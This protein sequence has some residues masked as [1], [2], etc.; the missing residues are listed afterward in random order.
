MEKNAWN[1]RI[2]KSLEKY[3]INSNN[4]FAFNKWL[5]KQ[6]A[7]TTLEKNSIFKLLYNCI[8]DRDVLW[9]KGLKRHP[10]CF[11]CEMEYEN[12]PHLFNA[13]DVA[14]PYLIRADAGTL[15]KKFEKLFT[16]LKTKTVSTILFGTY[17]EDK[18]KALFHL[19]RLYQTFSFT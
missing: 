10:L 19:N 3:S 17:T 9:D 4:L 6:D 15:G 16:L 7:I 12:I 11:L 18:D 1:N 2:Q 8:P 13:C 5:W 14:Q